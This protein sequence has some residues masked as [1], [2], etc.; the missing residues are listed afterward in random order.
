M[1]LLA[2]STTRLIKSQPLPFQQSYSLD[3]IY[4]KGIYDIERLINFLEREGRLRKNIVK[5]II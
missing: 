1:S 2:D 3:Q 5:K 4:S